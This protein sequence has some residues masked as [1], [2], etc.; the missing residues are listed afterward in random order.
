MLRR[1]FYCRNGIC[2]QFSA[3]WYQFYQ[4]WPSILGV[5]YILMQPLWCKSFHHNLF[6]HRPTTGLSRLKPVSSQID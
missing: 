5:H 6:W 2:G 3:K 1:K 4:N